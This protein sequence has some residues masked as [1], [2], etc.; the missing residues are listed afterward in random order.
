MKLT[1][2]ISGLISAVLSV[3]MI[4]VFS[5]GAEETEE[6]LY[7]FQEI[8]DMSDEEFFAT[9]PDAESGLENAKNFYKDIFR[10]QLIGKAE[11]LY[12]F[13]EDCTFVGGVNP[14]EVF[15]LE[16]FVENYLAEEY[17]LV[18]SGLCN[19]LKQSSSEK[20]LKYVPNMTEKNLNYI[21]GDY[22]SGM[23]SPIEF[24]YSEDSVFY[25]YLFSVQFKE[26]DSEKS[27][28]N[29]ENL[30]FMV[31]FDECLTQVL[32]SL[33]QPNGPLASS[34]EKKEVITGDV[35]LDKTVDL[36]DV[37]WI[38]NHLIHVFDLSEGQQKVG[39]INADGVCDIYDAIEIA[40]T[41]IVE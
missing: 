30:L 26:L 1:K 4:G 25:D 24:T 19:V 17:K 40:R 11:S 31:K 38:A 27:E 13:Y 7:T 3:S 41:L 10:T 37:I 15:T 20:E 34:G 29:D 18:Y 8:L 36:Y 2:V 23:K 14:T 22:I 12:D 39:D 35:N 28:I 16:E 9:F 21:F 33:W 5:A 6:K 32:P